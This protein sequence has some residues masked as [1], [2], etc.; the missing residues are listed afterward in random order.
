MW[1]MRTRGAF[2]AAAVFLAVA[3]SGCDTTPPAPVTSLNASSSAA[4]V[5]LTWTN[6]TDGDYAGAM[7]RRAPGAVPPASSSAGT[8]VGD[9]VK[10]GANLTDAGL[11]PS[12]TYSYAIFAHDG[13]PN[14]AAGV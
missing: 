7:V 8:L 9:V 4:S 5:T 10:P 11:T 3:V 14:Y 13:T 1:G 2:A 12:T 6:P